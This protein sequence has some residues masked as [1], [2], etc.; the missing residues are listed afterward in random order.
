VSASQETQVV[1]P[2]GQQQESSPRIMKQSDE[3]NSHSLFT[4]FC[5]AIVA[6]LNMTQKKPS[7]FDDTFQTEGRL[8]KGSVVLELYGSGLPGMRHKWQDLPNDLCICGGEWKYEEDHQGPF[9]IVQL[10]GAG[11]TSRV[12]RAVVQSQDKKTAYACI[13][14]YWIKVYDESNKK[15]FES[16]EI[17]HESNSSTTREVAYYK[18]IYGD[19]ASFVGR[20]KLNSRWCVILPFFKP[21][22]KNRRNKE[23]LEKIEKV[24]HEKFY[25]QEESK[26][27]QFKDCDWRWRHVGE[28]DNQI[29]LFDLADLVVVEDRDKTVHHKYVMNHIEGLRKR[30]PQQ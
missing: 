17:E 10:L 7:I 5:N 3:Y 11:E 28:R 15:M 6:S 14:K 30:M 20:K 2:G 13:L 23:T 18:K 16:T 21:I 22:P 24:L 4:V 27:Y 12:W 1:V 26:S 25:K 19:F 8:K 29:V 9:L